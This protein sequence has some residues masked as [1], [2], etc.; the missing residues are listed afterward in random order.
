MFFATLIS[1]VDPGS[2][3]CSKVP[4]IRSPL[5]DPINDSTRERAKVLIPG[6]LDLTASGPSLP[7][8]TARPGNYSG[9]PETDE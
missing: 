9:C 1:V 6:D 4:G 5:V 2:I 8:S 3:P 7:P